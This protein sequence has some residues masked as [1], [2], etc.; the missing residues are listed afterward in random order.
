MKCPMCKET[1]V[2]SRHETP[3]GGWN[4]GWLCGCDT[5]IRKQNEGLPVGCNVGLSGVITLPRDPRTGKAI[6]NSDMKQLCI[7]EF[8][9]G[10]ENSY[11][12]D[13]GEYIDSWE[14]VEVPWTTVKAIY[15]AMVA[16]AERTAT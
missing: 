4:F 9:F 10:R 2:P 15:K 13:D 6:V 11:I 5:E 8:K 12:D 14:D 3:E 16:A 7:G 1:M